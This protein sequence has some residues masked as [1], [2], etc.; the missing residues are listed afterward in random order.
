MSREREWS[1]EL[2][3]AVATL[4][5]AGVDAPRADA[6]LLLAHV[7]GGER[8]AVM[9]RVLAGAQAEPAQ[10]AV[11]AGLVERRAGREPLQ[12]LTGRACF[13]GVDLA[14][15]PGV[16]VP[17]P[18]TE[19]LVE[20]G[21]GALIADPQAERVLDLCTG[22][23]AVAAAVAAW[24]QAQGRRLR[25]TAVE[26]DPTAHSWARRNLEPWGVDLRL[27]DALDPIPELRGV[28]DVLLTNPPYV[29]DGEEPLQP[30]ARRDPDLAL[31]G[32]DAR[33]LRIP[34]RL[35]GAAAALLR[36]GGTFAMEHHETQGEALAAAAE[37]CGAFERVR[38]LPDATGR[39]RVLVAVRG[40]APEAPAAEWKNGPCE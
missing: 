11:F 3:E 19:L 24:G 21:I 39:D 31:Y 33:G 1:L 17:R 36:P 38:V 25:I 2:R 16:F 37:A 4:A 30:E 28:V 9:A 26:L 27:A 34:L 29:P 23:G 18:E 12:H 22:S 35:I 40:A 15:G 6:E 10:A 14:V 32:G 8:G 20:V 7:L 13:H 5:R